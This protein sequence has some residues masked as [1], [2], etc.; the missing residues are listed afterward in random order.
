MF[1]RAIKEINSYDKTKPFFVTLLTTSNHGP[2]IFP[3]DIGLKYKSK[4]VKNKIIEYV[5]WAIG[6]FMQKASKEE[7]F[8]N[9]L[10]VFIADHG[11]KKT[12]TTLYPMPLEYHHSPLI[13]YNPYYLQARKDY[14]LGLQIDV[15]EMICSYLGIENRQTMG[16]AFDLYKR[17]YAY[18]SADNKIGVLDK[19]L[20]YIWD[21][22]G[23]EYLF[24]YKKGRR[25]KKNYINS[26][27]YKSKIKEMK[28]YAFAMLTYAEKRN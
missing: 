22:N 12:K 20:F 26:P 15:D 4:T 25:D 8:K 19:E 3:E 21:R 10:F 7:W 24:K 17:K 2:Y 23:K 14:N 5:D 27:T 18:F 13:F 11:K 9:T 6:D 1:R 16:V 28:D